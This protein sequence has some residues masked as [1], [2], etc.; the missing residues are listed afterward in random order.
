[1]TKKETLAVT[2]PGG[3]IVAGISIFVFTP[4]GQIVFGENNKRDSSNEPIQGSETTDKNEIS[5]EINH[6]EINNA[7]EFLIKPYQPVELYER[8]LIITLNTYMS[9]STQKIELKLV[10]KETNN[11][12]LG[13]NLTMG[14]VIS[15]NNYLITLYKYKGGIKSSK[16][17]LYLKVEKSKRKPTIIEW[18]TLTVFISV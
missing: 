9:N 16:T 6:D 14:D 2:V 18:D 11:T 13:K 5:N 3:L 8:N 4:I 1:M 7:Y 10:N 15:F 17:G 12:E